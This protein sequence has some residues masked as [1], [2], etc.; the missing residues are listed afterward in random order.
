MV[1]LYFCENEWL[2]KKKKKSFAV[3]AAVPALI[4]LRVSGMRIVRE[5]EFP[6]LMKPILR[7]ERERGKRKKK[8]DRGEKK[9]SVQK[10]RRNTSFCSAPNTRQTY[11]ARLHG[12]TARLGYL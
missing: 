1:V 8:N 3:E 7:G 2:K 5:N 9:S 11:G 10:K 4:L 12:A 6:R